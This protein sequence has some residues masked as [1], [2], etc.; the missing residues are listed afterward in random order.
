MT[1]LTGSVKG[2]HTHPAERTAG[3][4]GR[5]PR[6]AAGPLPGVLAAAALLVLSS[7]QAEHEPTGAKLFAGAAPLN[8]R[9]YTQSEDLPDTLV[10]CANCHAH[11]RS[12]AVPRSTAPR[13]DKAFLTEPRHRRGGPRVAY[14]SLS[15]CAVVRSGIDPVHVVINVQMPRYRLTDEHCAALWRYLTESDDAGS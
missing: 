2:V 4:R 14:D 11:G 10:A 5:G 8:G 15:F 13:L 12:P 9:L 3:G 6:G 1:R 7:A